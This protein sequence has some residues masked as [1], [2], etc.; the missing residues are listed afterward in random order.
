MFHMRVRLSAHNVSITERNRCIMKKY[1]LIYVPNTGNENQDK[2]YCKLLRGLCLALSPQ[3]VK[4]VEDY[5]NPARSHIHVTTPKPPNRRDLK[6]SFPGRWVLRIATVCLVC[7]TPVTFGQYNPTPAG[8]INTNNNTISFLGI[9]ERS[10]DTPLGAFL[11]GFCL[12]VGFYLFG[13]L[14][15]MVRWP[16]HRG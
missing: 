14:L 15:R 6:D 9:G 5:S 3:D 16:G 13:W 12:V 4:I 8:D 10:L 11:A 2:W 7:Y 1:E